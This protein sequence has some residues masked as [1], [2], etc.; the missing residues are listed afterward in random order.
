MYIKLSTFIGTGATNAI[1]HPSTPKW[2]G[3]THENC[4]GTS[5]ID[6]QS[7]L[8]EEVKVVLCTC[9]GCGGLFEVPGDVFSNP[10]QLLSAS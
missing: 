2:F 3:E 4:M 9:I 6:F 5:A 1:E 8:V 10:Q 7:V